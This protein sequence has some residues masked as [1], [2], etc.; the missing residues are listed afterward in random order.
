MLATS[1]AA[2]GDRVTGQTDGRMPN[3]YIT[4]SAMDAANVTSYRI[5]VSRFV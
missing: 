4:L 3:R 5:G 1:H 2:L